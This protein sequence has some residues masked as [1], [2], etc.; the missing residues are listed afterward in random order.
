LRIL[1]YRTDKGIFINTPNKRSS[2]FIDPPLT[3]EK[4]LARVLPI[5]ETREAFSDNPWPLLFREMDAR[6]PGSKFVLTVRDPSEWIASM[7][8]HF[9][10]VPSDMMHWIYG[11]PCPLGHEERCLAIYEAHNA[12]VRAHFAGRPG[13]LLELDVTVSSRWD[14]LC[15]LLGKAIPKDP[16]PH[17]NPASER[18]RKRISLWQ[19]LKQTGRPANRA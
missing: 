2:I 14:E 13:D 16:F 1:G 17:E 5:A 10:G 15:T 12:S 19:R 8:R 18:E 11:V 3:S 7:V 6:F 9:G 4:V